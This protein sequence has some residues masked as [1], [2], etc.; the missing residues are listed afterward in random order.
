MKVSRNVPILLTERIDGGYS[1][2]CIV[3]PSCRCVGT[4]REDTLTTMRLLVG[5]AIRAG[6]RLVDG[7][8]DVVHLAVPGWPV[9]HAPAPARREPP[10][11]APSRV[12]GLRMHP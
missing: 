4:T 8:Y 10:V 1:A 7:N 5:A 12:V 2:Q 9:P 11:T 6:E 3:L